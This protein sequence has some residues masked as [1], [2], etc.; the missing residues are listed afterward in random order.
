MCYVD[1]LVSAAAT[2]QQAQAAY[3]HLL[4]LALHL[5]PS[6]CMPPTTQLEW[7]EIHLSPTTM[8][9]TTPRDQLVDVLRKYSP[10]TTSK[11]P[12]G[13]DSQSLQRL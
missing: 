6:K 10:C 8:G 12:S 9:V 5:S 3:D 11:R 4:Q 13:C 1:D 7:F 2:H